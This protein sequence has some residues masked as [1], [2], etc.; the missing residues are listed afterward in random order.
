[1]HEGFRSDRRFSGPT[2]GGGALL[3]GELHMERPPGSRL[4]F[5][6]APGVRDVEW[7]RGRSCGRPDPSLLLARPEPPCACRPLAVSLLD[8]AR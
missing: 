6:V 3:L 4:A 1:M 2:A 5:N 7:L 8:P